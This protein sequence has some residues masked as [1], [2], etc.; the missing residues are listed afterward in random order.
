MH[1]PFY[2]TSPPVPPMMNAALPNNSNYQFNGQYYP[3][4]NMQPTPAYQPAQFNNPPFNANFNTN[5][6]NTAANDF[7][8]FGL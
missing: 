3:N 5:S 2:A 7:N 1:Q 6:N 4:P 8:P